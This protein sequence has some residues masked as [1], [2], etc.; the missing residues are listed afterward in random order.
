VLLPRQPVDDQ[1]RDEQR[2]G[3]RDDRFGHHHSS[4]RVRARVTRGAGKSAAIVAIACAADVRVAQF[5]GSSWV[6]AGGWRDD[7]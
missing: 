4:F 5:L 7:A 2:G 3:N 1:Q 6:R